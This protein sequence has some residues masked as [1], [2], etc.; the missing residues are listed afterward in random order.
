[1]PPD[2]EGL[3]RKLVSV[4][5]L[6]FISS[7]PSI[8]FSFLKQITEIHHVCFIIGVKSNCE[9]FDDVSARPLREICVVQVIFIPAIGL[10]Y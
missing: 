6:I 3:T 5:R 10:R 7:K 2:V 9:R 4:A 8:S 1:M